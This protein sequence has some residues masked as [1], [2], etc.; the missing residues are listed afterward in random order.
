MFDYAFSYVFKRPIWFHFLHHSKIFRGGR[1][2]NLLT[3]NHHHH[4]RNA[5]IPFAPRVNLQA[6]VWM[7]ILLLGTFW[8]TLDSIPVPTETP[9]HHGAVLRGSSFVTCP[10]GQKLDIEDNC[11]VEIV[12]G[13]PK[14]SCHKIWPWCWFS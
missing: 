5:M 13:E 12:I 11:Q 4:H 6:A 9:N 3:H 10:P 8:T 2:L 14:E 1:Q 7:V